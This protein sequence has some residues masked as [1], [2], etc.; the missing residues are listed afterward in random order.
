MTI[1]KVGRLQKKKLFARGIAAS[2]SAFSE[3]GGGFWMQ[4]VKPKEQGDFS[5]EPESGFL[6]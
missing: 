3:K 6:L 1:I 5:Y 2:G 4:K